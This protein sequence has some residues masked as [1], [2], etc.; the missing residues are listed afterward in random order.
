MKNVIP[1]NVTPCSSEGV[2]GHFKGNAALVL[3]L[4]DSYIAGYSLGLH[5]V[6][7]DGECYISPERRRTSIGLHV[8]ASKKAVFFIVTAVRNSNSREKLSHRA[9]L[10]V[11]LRQ[12]SPPNL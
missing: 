7:E 8:I 1:W 2:Y 12:Y 6:S 9:K 11:H 4:L 10:L 5:F 3:P